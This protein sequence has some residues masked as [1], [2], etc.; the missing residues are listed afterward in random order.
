MRTFGTGVSELTL[1]GDVDAQLRGTLCCRPIFRGIAPSQ[2]ELSPWLAERIAHHCDLFRRLL[3]PLL[4]DCKVYH[5]MPFLRHEDADPW[6][7]LE[8]ASPDCARAVAVIF[9][10]APTGA[11]TYQLLP[12]GLDAGRRYRIYS[13]NHDWSYETAGSELIQQGL[14]VGS[15]RRLHCRPNR[16]GSHYSPTADLAPVGLRRAYCCRND[17]LCAFRPAGSHRAALKFRDCARC[18]DC[19]WFGRDTY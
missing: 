7:V 5:H 4:L 13:D 11:D 15:R 14:R 10:Q 18:A 8:Y 1:D 9:R 17:G 19:V 16:L 6:V 12:R 2:P 3:R